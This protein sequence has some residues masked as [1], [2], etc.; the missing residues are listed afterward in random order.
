MLL[1]VREAALLLW[2]WPHLP[3]N[4]HK[5]NLT[6]SLIEDSEINDQA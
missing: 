1:Q 2:A 5:T 4:G 3:E 6:D